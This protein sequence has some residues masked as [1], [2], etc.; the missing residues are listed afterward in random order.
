M[1]VAL[2]GG[3]FRAQAR[4]NP[5]TGRAIRP[6]ASL[7]GLVTARVA[8]RFIFKAFMPGNA[9]GES[10]PA[11]RPGAACFEPMLDARRTR[12]QAAPV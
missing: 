8:F 4:R 2:S 9:I 11:I 10:R 3:R 7:G 12:N 5:E 1:P 6:S